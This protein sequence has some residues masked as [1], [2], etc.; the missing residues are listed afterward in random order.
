MALPGKPFAKFAQILRQI[1]PTVLAAAGGP[2][3]VLAATVLKKTLGD[4][5]MTDAKL[6][7][8]VAAATSSPEGLAKLRQAELDIQKIESDTG[9]RFAELE[10][11][12][13]A[14]AR[15]LA[16]KTSIAPQVILSLIFVLGYFVVLTFF[17]YADKSMPMSEAFTLMLGVLTAGIPQIMAYW[18]GSS[19]GSAAKS[20][21][22]NAMV[23]S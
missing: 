5:T 21:T 10:V 2:A 1:A 22:I 12:D 13:R 18:L 23:K 8:E 3:G 11:Q 6:E 4:E 14:G 15:D 17:F 7:E 20:D 16:I 9:I 19:S